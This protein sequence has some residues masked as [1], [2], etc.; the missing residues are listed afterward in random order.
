MLSNDQTL[1]KFI[2]SSP[3]TSMGDV[4][5]LMGVIDKALP[6]TDGLKWFNL[7][8]LRVTEAVQNRVS[9]GT[10][11]D[12]DWLQRLDILFAKLYFD[13]YV[14]GQRRPAVAS[15]AWAP[16]F[17][18][19]Q[20]NDIARLQYAL[21]GMNAHINH[22]LCVAIVQTCKEKRITPMRKSPQHQDFI[23]VNDI[24]VEV[25]GKVKA[26][27][28][29]GPL[30]DLDKDLGQL[31]DILA[32]WSVRHARNAAWTHAQTL[33]ELQESTFLRESFL[34]TLDQFTGFAGRGLLH[35]I[36]S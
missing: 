17:E 1:A 34:R 21:A 27:L 11:G 14:T 7:L 22:D 26:D 23:R 4:I 31:D 2:A 6:E 33:W 12:P 19:R 29:T 5:S 20:R 18:N 3:V 28:L 16:L 8:Y 9:A 15:K 36:A 30:R 24:L 13:A 25:E 32:M 10:W 35:P